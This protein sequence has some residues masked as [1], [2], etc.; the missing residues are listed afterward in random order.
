MAAC[1]KE[2]YIPS[3]PDVSI[4]VSS[5]HVV[6]DSAG[7]EK[8][9]VV[10]SDFSW[11]C[12]CE[13]NWF[14]VSEDD[15]GIRIVASANDGDETRYG[16]LTVIAYY[17]NAAAVREISVA[18]TGK[19]EVA[20]LGDPANCYVVNTGKTYS[21]DATVKGCGYDDRY[22]GVRVYISQ[23]G[24]TIDPSEIVYADLLW[25]AAFDADKTRS[26]GI[27]SGDPL[28]I[29]GRIRFTTGSCE[30]NAVI[31]A[32]NAQ[33]TV[34]WSWHIWVCDSD[35]GETS[36]NGHTWM[37]RNLGAISDADGDINNR[38]LLYQ[39]GRKD[40]FLPSCAGYG[41][42]DA[43]V[44][45]I[46]VGDGSGLWNYTDFTTM[47]SSAAPGNIVLAVENPMSLLQSNGSTYAWY[48][49]AA[50]SDLY[51]AFLWGDSDKSS[52]TKSIFDP[53]PAGYMVP[54]RKPWNTATLTD[55]TAGQY[56]LYWNDG[57]G[58]YYP[59]VGCIMSGACALTGEGGYYWS[60][61]MYSSDSSY[62][63]DYLV[64]DL[65]SRPSFYASY[66]LY[67]FP[68]RCVREE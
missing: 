67:A 41:E 19:V 4:E 56:G 12:L 27:I 44:F 37:D 39:W 7:G 24:L 47:R 36:G 22:G 30:G 33:G 42:A 62:Y 53:C 57:E 13:D 52:M 66:P 2:T 5:T 54:N 65:V 31:A 9:V 14:S 46:Q 48:M 49:T 23:Y 60:A 16:T 35:V 3:D 15:S 40:P 38:G 51:S 61:D 21:F 28:Y 10:V 34:L 6:F 8:T 25:E 11:E 43:N 29:D 17:Q 68:V 55:W 59:A 64:F 18:Q 45:N 1:T 26:C 58:A 63:T 20:D 50:S 32:K